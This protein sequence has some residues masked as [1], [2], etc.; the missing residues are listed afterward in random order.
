MRLKRLSLRI[1]IFIAMILLVLIASILIAA[2]TI[3]QYNEEAQSYH[4]DRLERK[5]ENI[6]RHIVFMIRETT[7]EVK[8][9]KLPLIFKD[10]IYK[11][12]DIHQSQM[13]LYDLEGGLLKSSKASLEGD[14]NAQCLSSEILNALSNT[15]SHRFVLKTKENDEVDRKSVV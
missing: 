8:T 5:E 11:I 10:E 15:G 1:R 4:K 7:F 6:K 12:A 13:N 3:Y 2:V 9:E 14:A